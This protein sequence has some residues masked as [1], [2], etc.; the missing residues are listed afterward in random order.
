MTVTH[1][2]APPDDSED[3][4]PPESGEGISDLEETIIDEVAE[5]S[6]QPWLK[7]VWGWVKSR[8]KLSVRRPVFSASA[9]MGAA[10][11]A[12]VAVLRAAEA[13]SIGEVILVALFGASVVISIVLCFVVNSKGVGS[14]DAG[15]FALLAVLLLTVGYGGM[16]LTMVVTNVNPDDSWIRSLGAV[17]LVLSVSTF[18]LASRSSETDANSNG[19][20]YDLIQK[21]LFH[22]LGSAIF[23]AGTAVIALGVRDM[24]GTLLYRGFPLIAEGALVAFLGLALLLSR[25]AWSAILMVG[26]GIAVLSTGVASIVNSQPDFGS[27]T[28]AVGMSGIL[29]AAA[30]LRKSAALGKVGFVLGGAGSAAMGWNAVNTHTYAF[31]ITMFAVALV[32]IVT[33]ATLMTLPITRWQEGDKADLHEPWRR[34]TA[35]VVG[36][37]TLIAGA[38]AVSAVAP[39][40]L[41]G[42][43]ATAVQV[44]GLAAS[45]VAIGVLVIICRGSLSPLP[46]P[47]SDQ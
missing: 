10:M 41:S 11:G 4:P 44:S 25:R 46:L 40:A 9:A 34:S 27:S 20:K 7:R 22:L 43:T 17:W 30:I 6:R 8:E 39:A 12:T 23:G 21:I 15:H 33:A 16:T 26:A 37:L 24:A 45:L 32:M 5:S 18:A 42:D 47:L 36:V 19:R 31:G 35:I 13:D 14:T 29:L 38:L 2:S 1:P 28:V 3:T